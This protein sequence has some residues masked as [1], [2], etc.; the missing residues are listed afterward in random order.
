MVVAAARYSV[1]LLESLRLCRETKVRSN[2]WMDGWIAQRKT[3][4]DRFDG[5]D[6][7]DVKRGGIR[8]EMIAR[9]CHRQSKSVQVAYVDR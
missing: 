9:V 1:A 4:V 8:S 5:S 2:E 3:G 6:W 7:R